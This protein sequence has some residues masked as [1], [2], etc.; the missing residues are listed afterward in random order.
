MAI[1]MHTGDL[2]RPMK[3]SVGGTCNGHVV[4]S[5]QYEGHGAHAGGSPHL[6]INALNAAMVA[7]HSMNA[8]RE[9][10]RDDE[11][12]RFHGIINRGGDAVSAIPS[13]VR[14]EWR[15]RAGSISSVHENNKRLDRSFKAGALAVGAKV[16]I[17][18]IPGYFPIHNDKTMKNIF[19]ESAQY[20]IGNDHLQ[21]VSDDVNIGH[22]S[23]LGDLSYVLPT[24]GFN[25]AGISGVGHGKD[26]LVEDW[27]NTIINT[28]KVYATF[29]ID[30]LHSD[31]SPAK[32]VISS[33]KLDM[34]RSE[35]LKF[36]REQA[37]EIHFDGA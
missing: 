15:V 17:N 19:I 11:M 9:T 20:V 32:K 10:F 34:T 22:S 36:Q 3:M 30:L 14:L 6:G 33:A 13:D 27:E 2:P 28:A 21:I 23:D 16:N 5:V 24:L 1:R 29:T 18:T 8:N 31:A 4:K 25:V 7:I 35:Y 37:E 26:Y 12:V